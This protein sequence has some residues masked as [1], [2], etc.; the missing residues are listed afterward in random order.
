MSIYTLNQDRCIILVEAYPHSRVTL[1]QQAGW[2]LQARQTIHF[3]DPYVAHIE[4]LHS[5]STRRWHTYWNRL[6]VVRTT[7]WGLKK[8][9]VSDTW[10]TRFFKPQNNLTTFANGRFYRATTGA[11][12]IKTRHILCGCGRSTCQNATN[13]KITEWFTQ[14][15]HHK[16]Q[17]IYSWALMM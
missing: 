12:G 3:P 8:E 13:Q 5:C 10:A 11:I 2:S 4:N 9:V 15:F 14:N 7:W 6:L 16:L 1:Q 17:H